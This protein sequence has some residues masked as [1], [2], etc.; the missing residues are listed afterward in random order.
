MNVNSK[1][2][3]VELTNAWTSVQSLTHLRPVRDEDGFERMQ[4]LCNW[5]ADEVGDDENHP[6]YSMFDLVMQLI[7]DWESEHVFIPQAQ[8]R[9]VL[10]HLLEVNNLK[11]KDLSEIASHTLISDILNGR[12]EISKRLAKALS[13]RFHVD[14]AAFV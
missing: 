3:F 14:V 13:E 7:E 8:P 9:E 2:E 6:L 5:L 1:R 4:Q 10:R 11:Q 12:R